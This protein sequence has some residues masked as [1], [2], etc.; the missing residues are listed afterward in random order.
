[1]GG[2]TAEVRSHIKEKGLFTFKS[3]S[4]QST[5]ETAEPIRNEQRGKYVSDFTVPVCDDQKCQLEIQKDLDHTTSVSNF[6]PGEHRTVP[7]IEMCDKRPSMADHFKNLKIISNEYQYFG[8]CATLLSP[9]LVNVYDSYKT[10]R[11]VKG[12]LEALQD[13]LYL[14]WNAVSHF[15]W[16]N[17]GKGT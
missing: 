8:E 6:L 14:N 16:M 4:Q 1:M 15:K 10:S 7:S 12:K 2:T 17:K 3:T 9:P 11:D 5:E 13:G